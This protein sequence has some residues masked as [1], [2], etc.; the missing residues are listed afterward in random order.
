LRAVGCYGERRMAE[1]DVAALGAKGI[2]A[3]VEPR[4][5]GRVGL[6]SLTTARAGL[7]PDGVFV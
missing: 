5:D 7:D 4:G 2:E 1:K 6:A 3:L